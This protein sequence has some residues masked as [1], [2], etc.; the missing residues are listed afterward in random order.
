VDSNGKGNLLGRIFTVKKLNSQVKT[1]QVTRITPTDDGKFDIEALH[2][3]VNS[4]GILLM[5]VGWD[6]GSNWVISR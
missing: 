6:N 3:P 2:S 4:S 5:A 1:Y